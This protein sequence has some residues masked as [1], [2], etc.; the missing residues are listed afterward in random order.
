[1][2]SI[3]ICLLRWEYHLWVILDSSSFLFHGIQCS[4]QSGQYYQKIARNQSLPSMPAAINPSRPCSLNL[5]PAHSILC[6]S[7]CLFLKYL[8]FLLF[9]LDSL[10]ASYCDQNKIQS[11][12]LP[13]WGSAWSGP[14]WLL[15]LH[16]SR[17]PPSH[18]LCPSNTGLCASKTYW[19]HLC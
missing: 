7:Q 9:C 15:Q 18:S 17:I 14:H 11:L 3:C 6:S 19:A 1:M 2:V 12:T 4:S 10:M 16:L 5:S 13:L 8:S